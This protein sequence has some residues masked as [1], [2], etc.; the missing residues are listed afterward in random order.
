M[1]YRTK[2]GLPVGKVFTGSKF[3][4]VN[5]VEARD[6]L[7]PEDLTMAKDNPY[8]IAREMDNRAYLESV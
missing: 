1:L 8:D 6:D 2:H 3:K 5:Y 4:P 7:R